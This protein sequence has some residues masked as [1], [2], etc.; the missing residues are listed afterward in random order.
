MLNA[1][2]VLDQRSIPRSSRA[3][4]AIVVVVVVVPWL[5]Q[6]VAIEEADMSTGGLG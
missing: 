4:L 2:A 1:G 6:H 3:V 5:A